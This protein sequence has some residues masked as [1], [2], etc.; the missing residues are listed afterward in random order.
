MQQSLTGIL[1]KKLDFLSKLSLIQI[2][3]SET[4]NKKFSRIIPANKKNLE[5]QMIRYELF[6]NKL[7]MQ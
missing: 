3:N 4:N 6:K 2:H 5:T 1:R 7:S